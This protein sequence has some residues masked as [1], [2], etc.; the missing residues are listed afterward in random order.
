MQGVSES[1]ASSE[2]IAAFIDGSL[3]E[4]DRTELEAHLEVCAGCRRE[5]NE[6]AQFL[7][8]RSSRRRWL[9]A[10]PIAAAIVGL[11]LLYPGS[12]SPLPDRSVQ[13]ERGAEATA[14]R[15][16]LLPVEVIA[17]PEDV[18]IE[19]AALAFVWRG[20]E[21]GTTFRL[22]LTD[23]SGRPVWSTE[24]SDTTVTLPV[25]VALEDGERYLWYVDALLPDG[26]EASSGVRILS[27]AP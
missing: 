3:T 17:P 1:H 12:R 13:V 24:V 5:A 4:T 23:D 7:R 11:L 18:P 6:V 2:E 9:V 21:T 19:P 22:T 26:R 20:L 16:A 15:E 8:E 25:T 10:A 14:Q 27:M